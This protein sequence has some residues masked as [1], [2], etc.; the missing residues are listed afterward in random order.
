MTWRPRLRVWSVWVS[1]VVRLA[2]AGIFI[3][4][5]ALKA[6]DPSAAVQAV[7]AYALLPSSWET[8]VGWALPFFEIALGL[9]LVAGIMTRAVAGVSVLLLLAFITAVIS[10]AVR[11]LSIDCGCFG[12][13]GAI[14]DGQ[15]QYATEIIRDV[16]FLALAVWL[17]WRPAS[18]F[19]LQPEHEENL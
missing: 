4:A 9:L 16:G 7:Q 13:G 1:T 2:L 17:V 14:A 19:S 10:A 11:G 6:V 3:A 12:G 18:H 15:T 8:L 5:G